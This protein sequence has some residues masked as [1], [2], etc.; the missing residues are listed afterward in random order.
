MSAWPQQE[1]SGVRA[2]RAGEAALI[3]VA[4]DITSESS[5][6]RVVGAAGRWAGAVLFLA[7]AGAD[8]VTGQTVVVDGG[9]FM[10]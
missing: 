6:E 4:A 8:F 9:R 7:S 5:C 1:P 10:S 2:S 3:T